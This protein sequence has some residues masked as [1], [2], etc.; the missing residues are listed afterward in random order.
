MSEIIKDWK[1]LW[2]KNYRGEGATEGLQKLVKTLT[3]GSRD[4]V[5]Y[6]GWATVERIFKFQDGE[7]EAVISP[8]GNFVH[9]DRAF[10]KND[11]EGIPL[12]MNSYFIVIK[13]RWQG[14]EHIETY[15]LQDSNGRPLSFWTQNDINKAVQRAKVKA[16]AMVSG[17]GYK[18]Y[19]DGDLQ[20]EDDGKD[21]TK[22]PK[23]EEP[24]PVKPKS[25]KKADP[26]K[27]VD[28]VVEPVVEPPVEDEKV[29][30][31]AE[32]TVIPAEE[33]SVVYDDT[34]TEAKAEEITLT[35]TQM[36]ERIK[37]EFLQGGIPKVTIVRNSLN[38]YG[39]KKIDELDDAALRELYILVTAK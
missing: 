24:A 27:T 12:Y 20:F 16:I 29:S 3:Y 21:G 18:L 9:I 1:E 2:L 11:E 32:Q 10:I 33:E 22:A 5:S 6:L 19:E 28:S 36:I 26:V 31:P 38:K 8:D 17:I 13:A 23:V 7:Y 25:P 35:K 15:P 34:K 37:T 39:A 30:E 4:G 14:Q